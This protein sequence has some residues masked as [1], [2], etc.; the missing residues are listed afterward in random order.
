MILNQAQAQA[1]YTAMCALNNVSAN[2]GVQISF[3]GTVDG[4]YKHIKVEECA[5]GSVEVSFG[6]L[7]RERETYPNQAAF[8]AAYNLA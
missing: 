3:V 4:D 8:A 2:E 5:G 6:I 7:G 1:V